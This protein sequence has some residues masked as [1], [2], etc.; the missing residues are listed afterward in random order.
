MSRERGS[1]AGILPTLLDG[2]E[3]ERERAR[4][5]WRA[6]PQ[7]GPKGTLC[8]CRYDEVMAFD[9]TSAQPSGT[10]QR[11]VS[12]AVGQGVMGAR[13]VA[14]FIDLVVLTVLFVAMG[15]IFGGAHSQTATSL[16]NPSVHQTNHSVSLTG[17]SFV[18]FVILCL[19]YYFVLESRSGQTI[20]KR[21]MGVRVVDLDGGRPTTG[22]VFR[23]TLGRLVD[24]LP[25]LY[26]V[27]LIATGFGQR[28]QRIGDRLAHTTVASA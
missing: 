17:G 22:A 28:R 5:G 26:Q 24:V 7:A 14:G 12:T 11:A 1:D 8:P 3:S 6:D 23:R 16:S 2:D 27:G 10:P 25:L 18:L 19:A 9:A 21:L 15:L 20:G 13:I 4:T